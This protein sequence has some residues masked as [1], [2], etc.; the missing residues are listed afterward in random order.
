M[1]TVEKAVVGFVLGWLLLLAGAV[2]L[3]SAPFFR[4]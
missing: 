1:T 3:M 4:L 2:V